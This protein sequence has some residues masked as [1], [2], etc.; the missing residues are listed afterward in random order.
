MRLKVVVPDVLCSAVCN[1]N[2][3]A[4]TPFFQTIMNWILIFPAIVVWVKDM[5]PE[6]VVTGA[7][8]VSVMVAVR[9]VATDV[10]KTLVGD[11]GPDKPIFAPPVGAEALI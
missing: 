5:L 6:P 3:P 4:F 10:N 2:V 1:T 8:C 9:G 7:P 11:A